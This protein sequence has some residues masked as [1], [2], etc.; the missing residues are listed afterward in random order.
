MAASLWFIPT[1]VL[2]DRGKEIELEFQIHR[3]MK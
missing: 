2:P 1:F 3:V